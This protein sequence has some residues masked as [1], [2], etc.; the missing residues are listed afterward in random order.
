MDAADQ[1]GPCGEA[2]VITHLIIAHLII[3]I[4]CHHR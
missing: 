1:A 3:G 4:A 2:I